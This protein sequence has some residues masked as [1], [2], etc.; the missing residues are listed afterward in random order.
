MLPTAGLPTA[1]GSATTA[2]AA[3]ESTE[4]ATTGPSAAK[5]TATP[6]T[7]TARAAARVDE[8]AQ[9]EPQEAAASGTA[10]AATFIAGRDGT[11]DDEKN[12]EAN[13]GE[14]SYGGVVVTAGAN[15]PARRLTG[16]GDVGVIGDEFGDLPSGGFGR[17]AVVTLAKRGNH[18]AADVPDARVVDDG[19]KAVAD[20]DAIFA[21][22]GGE[23]EEDAAIVFFAA[24]AELFK[25]VDGGFFNA[26][27][28]E[29]FFGDDGDL[30]AGFLLD[31]EAEGFQAGLGSGVNYPG[32]IGD[33]TAGAKILEVV[34]MR[35][36]RCA[37]KKAQEREEFGKW[38]MV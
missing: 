30:D 13:Y 37:E 12:D 20:L 18:G 1:G 19:L 22:G 5:S 26:P 32:A 36:K 9:D 27:A 14:K 17:L 38:A 35:K 21:V 3:A 7:A 28:V 24:H 16:E 33:E 6:T 31:F 15:L 8:H 11:D 23:E 4:A 10:T 2:A 25:D 34:G 29:R